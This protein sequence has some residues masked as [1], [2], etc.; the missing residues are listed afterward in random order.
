[1]TKQRRCAVC[2]KSLKHKKV[3]DAYDDKLI[4]LECGA[5]HTFAPNG[6]LVRGHWEFEPGTCFRVLVRQ[7]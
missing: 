7:S 6:E 5:T 3:A 2:K 1:M 4:C